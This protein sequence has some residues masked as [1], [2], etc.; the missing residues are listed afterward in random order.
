MFVELVYGIMTNSLG[1]ISDSAH[2]FFDCS[3]LV[4][5]LLAS[6]FASFP[7][8][9]R[10]SYGYGRIEVLSGLTNCVFL[11]FVALS[12]VMESVERLMNPQVIH[13]DRLLTVAVLGLLVN[14]VG[15]AFFHS[16][17]HEHHHHHSHDK[18]ETELKSMEKSK[19][20]NIEHAEHEA[21]AVEANITECKVEKYHYHEET[22]AE[23]HHEDH[24]HNEHHEQHEHCEH[25]EHHEN[26]NLS[27]VFLHILA[28]ALGSVGV[29]ISS[30]LIKYFDL[31]IA[32]SICSLI[33][34]GLILMSIVPLFKST[35][36]VLILHAPKEVKENLEAIGA[37]I[38]SL[39]NVCECTQLRIWRFRKNELVASLKIEVDSHCSR[40][41]LLLK[42][43]SLLAHKGIVHSTIEIQQISSSD[44]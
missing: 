5:S 27:G 4:L 14:L 43:K 1:L 21:Y 22:H 6:Y 2:M 19:D 44:E 13:S 37:E 30:A 12:I 36:S 42:L 18:E 10:F 7:P 9:E 11:V 33:I 3:A 15:I 39:K 23:R 32:D 26:E 24:N 29:I 40:S 38:L 17:S 25:H 16:H 35:L 8:S 31:L 41:E 28:D 20:A 34:S